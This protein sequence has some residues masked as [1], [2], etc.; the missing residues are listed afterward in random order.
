MTLANWGLLPINDVLPLA[1]YD[2]YQKPKE[3]SRCDPLMLLS[4]AILAEL[5]SL[6]IHIIPTRASCSFS[7]GMC[8]ISLLLSVLLDSKYT[9]LGVSKGLLGVIKGL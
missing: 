2:R 9:H 6:L 5:S 4:T 3:P 7:N 1:E 8:T